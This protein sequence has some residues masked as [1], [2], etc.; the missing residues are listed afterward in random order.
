MSGKFA[1]MTLRVT[2]A[3]D[4]AVTLLSCLQISLSYGCTAL[5]D[6][7]GKGLKSQRPIRGLGWW[8][9]LKIFVRSRERARRVP[10]RLL[11]FEF[12]MFE[13][14]L[15]GLV[16]IGLGGVGFDSIKGL[17]GWIGPFVEWESGRRV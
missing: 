12:A 6:F 7:W 9:W 16:E 15:A 14:G 13:M 2:L 5:R 10:E 1:Q 17:H 4:P 3:G 8:K 11:G